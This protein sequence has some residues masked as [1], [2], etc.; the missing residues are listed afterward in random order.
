MGLVTVALTASNFI[1]GGDVWSLSFL[2][3]G[4]V[5]TFIAWKVPG[6]V[7]GRIMIGLSTVSALADSEA[8]Q[9]VASAFG[10]VG[11]ATPLFMGLFL[12]TFPTGHFSRPWWRTVS[13]VALGVTVVGFV[14][15]AATGDEGPY[16]LVP[17]F[18]FLMGAV[19]DLLVRYRNES[20]DQK[21]Q[22]KYVVFAT[23]STAS[24]LV[25]PG[26]AGVPDV[27][28]DI[29]VVVGFTLV[30]LAVGG[31]ILKYRLYDLDR[32]ISRTVSYTL[33]VLALGA[34]FAALTWIPSLVA[35]GIN[36]DGTLGA[37]PAPVV[38]AASTLAVAALFNPVR[39]RVQ[40]R[41]DR[42]FNRSRYQAEAIAEG[43]SAQLQE[44]LTVEGIS[45]AWTQIVQEV[46]HPEVTGIW[47][48]KTPTTPQEP[49]SGHP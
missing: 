33:V 25:L 41:V 24:L 39:K 26:V 23:F 46:L 38:V 45:E 17:L 11:V 27:V 13:L 6:H 29:A 48:K 22:M 30:P 49:D 21:A 10:W 47:I 12:L 15:I 37:G 34:V 43:F 20:G 28:F 19:I 36:D 18:V 44:S 4:V 14:V 35:G 9:G 2:G 42:R 8:L 5:G 7:T 1:V 3:F 31:A 40:R 32:L 16:V